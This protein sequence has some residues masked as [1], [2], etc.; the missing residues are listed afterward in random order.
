M[1]T[2]WGINTNQ[3]DLPHLLLRAV[4]KLPR[5]NPW[6]CSAVSSELL[7]ALLLWEPH[8]KSIS[9][10]SHWAQLCPGVNP[11]EEGRTWQFHQD[12][13]ESQGASDKARN[14]VA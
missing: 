5:T 7:K 3:D 13:K 1:H 6:G 14:T 10:S 2:L 12:G 11:R 4:Q 8:C 9:Q